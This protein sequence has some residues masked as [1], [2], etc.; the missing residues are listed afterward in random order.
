MLRR[1]DITRLGNRRSKDPC[2]C[3][4]C[5]EIPN[6]ECLSYK[7][8]RKYILV[9]GWGNLR[10]AVAGILDDDRFPGG[11]EGKVA[12]LAGL[13]DL[14]LPADLEFVQRYL[15]AVRDNSPAPVFDSDSD[16][17]SGTQA[18][19]SGEE[20]DGDSDSS[21]DSRKNWSPTF[22]AQYQAV[23]DSC[24]RPRMGVGPPPNM[25]YWVEWKR[26]QDEINPPAHQ[27]ARPPY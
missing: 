2:I 7:T 4:H 16:S 13:L 24:P 3:F 5:C 20:E 10:T 19:G 23:L 26:Q 25:D 22:E 6:Q 14:A 18:G 27:S 11:Q 8:R 17:D 9:N 21:N 15:D 12:A 1:I